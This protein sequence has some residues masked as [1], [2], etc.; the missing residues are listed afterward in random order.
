MN[1][2]LRPTGKDG[3]AG[4]T[5]VEGVCFTEDYDNLDISIAVASAD[6][7][8]MLNN[9][10]DLEYFTS[11]PS[12]GFEGAKAMYSTLSRRLSFVPKVIEAVRTE[13][14]RPLVLAYIAMEVK[15]L[16]FNAIPQLQAIKL[17]VD[18]CLQRIAMGLDMF[19]HPPQWVPRLSYSRYHERIMNRISAVETLEDKLKSYGSNSRPALQATMDDTAKQLM[20]INIRIE[21]IGA[22]NGM[23]NSSAT[24][25]AVYTPA[26][27]KK[28]Q[29]IKDAIASVQDMIRDHI[30]VDPQTVIDAITII[31]FAPTAPMMGIQLI[32]LYHKSTSSIKALDGTMVE[33]KYVVNQFSTVDN[34]FSK[35]EEGYRNRSNG[36]IEVDD[37]GADKLIASQS[38]LDDLL[39]KYK[40]AIK[41]GSAESIKKELDAYIDLVKRRNE[42]VMRYNAAVQLL[43]QA[44]AEK[45][46][47]EQQQAKYGEALLS[48]DPTLPAG[49][50]WMRKFINDARFSAIEALIT[51]A[52]ALGFWA[53]TP[54]V[55]FAQLFP[56]LPT[57]TLLSQYNDDLEADFQ[58]CV[59]QYGGK[60][61]NQFPTAVDR[62]HG[63]QGLCHYFTQDEVTAFK[64]SA[65]SNLKRIHEIFFSIP[66][67]KSDTSSNIS[68][69]A[70]YWDVRIDQARVWL[71]GAEVTPGI[72]GIRRL[73]VGL[74]HLGSETITKFDEV[75]KFLEFQ[76]DPVS[77]NFSYDPLGI[78]DFQSSS[79]ARIHSAQEFTGV[80][81]GQKVDVKSDS[82]APIGPFGEWRLTV[83][84]IYNNDLSLS[85][86]TGI[87]I[88]FWGSAVSFG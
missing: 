73:S 14:T 21:L 33:K 61:Y 35:L 30:N 74:T 15:K 77:L 88:E 37:P 13:K 85:K 50:F 51:G 65:D 12:S 39:T 16:A 36:L 78:V 66:V 42:A 34:T 8:Q 44:L 46:L 72:D 58:K 24:Q 29:V 86:V 7:C 81:R 60:I 18:I 56:G 23:L 40:E 6:Q 53:L 47:Y 48:L 5:C 2:L 25:I 26:L 62:E 59:N 31:A 10:A 69:F 83:N 63:G 79:H 38:D 68:L 27:K 19:G 76:H 43:M 41:S 55:Q 32:G 64:G 71:F 75:D 80:Y 67:V 22:S 57:T 17:R 84:P 45:T 11:R 49:R 54:P 52:R 9:R 3:K 82:L 87:C 70:G 28:R 4:T 20:D 1:V